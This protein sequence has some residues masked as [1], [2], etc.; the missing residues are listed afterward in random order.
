GFDYASLAKEPGYIYGGPKVYLFSIYPTFLAL[1]MTWI[2]STKAFLIVNHLIA[3]GMG[4]GIVAL[5]R[6]ILKTVTNNQ[7]ALLTAL[8]L[9]FIPLFQGQVE[10]INMEIPMTFFAVWAMFYLVKKKM[11]MACI[12]AVISTMVKGV[13]IYMPAAVAVISLWL[14]FFDMQKRFQ[15]KK[16][17]VAFAGVGFVFLKLYAA[18]FILNEEGSADMVGPLEGWFE[19]KYFPETYFFLI[20]IMVLGGGFLWQWIKERKKFLSLMEKYYCVWGFLIATAG[21]FAVFINSYAQFPRYRLLVMP[22]IVFI[23]FYVLQLLVKNEKLLQRSII[24][25]IMISLICSYGFAHPKI[26]NEQDQVQDHVILER[27]LEYRNDINFRIKLARDIEQQF[28]DYKIGAPFLLAH[29]LALPELGYV[30]KKL[31]V[32]IYGF[33]CKLD[34]ITVFRG[35]EHLDLRKTIWVAVASVVPEHMKRFGAYPIDP[36]DIIVEKRFYGKREAT[37]FKGGIAMERMRLISKEV[38]KQLHK[39]G[40]LKDP[41]QHNFG[42]EEVERHR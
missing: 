30:S 35:L 6:E 38:L 12:M 40:L 34:G 13:A 18:F 2:S 4:A 5:F 36:K 11:G 19:M 16:L 28:A 42:L 25:V 23:T 26:N 37:L 15:W 33:P 39:K 7:N 27:S 31:D 22:F 9:L 24:G 3:L 21:W 41:N 14:F 29:S 10:M 8:V 32:M 17:F 1:L 20:S